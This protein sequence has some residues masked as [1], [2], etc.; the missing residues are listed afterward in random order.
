[1]R[2]TPA[3][4]YSS[5]A[6]SVSKWWDPAHTFSSDARNLS[7]DARPMGC[8]CEKLPGGGGVRHM[9]VV[10]AAPGKALVMSGGL[11][12]LLSLPATGTMAIGISATPEGTKLV[13]TYGVA[14]YLPAGMNTWAAPVDAVLNQQ[15]TRLKNYI[16]HGDPAVNSGN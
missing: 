15:F 10:Y 5:L 6:D 9:Q 1:M 8:F 7:I 13:V 16:E 4:V 11:G 14:G 2:T 3:N 12:P